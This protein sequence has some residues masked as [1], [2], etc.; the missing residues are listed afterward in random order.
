MKVDDQVH[1]HNCPVG[2]DTIICGCAE[3]LVAVIGKNC[4]I[5]GGVGIR[6]KAYHLC[7]SVTVM[8]SAIRKSIDIPGT[9]KVAPLSQNMGSG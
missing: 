8:M 7:D 6:T 9:Y 5:A 1:G 4:V 2:E 3:W